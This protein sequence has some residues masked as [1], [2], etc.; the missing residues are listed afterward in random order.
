MYDL[1][2]RNGRIMDG[3][4]SSWCFADVAIVD[5]RIA[6]MERHLDGKARHEIDASG[7]VVS[8]G[9]IDTHSHSDVTLLVNP[10]AES[11]VRQGVTTQLVG[12][13]GFSAAPVRPENQTTLRRDSFI[14]S[15]EGYEW[16]WNDVAGY[17]AAL[18]DARPAINV[19]TLVG[20]GALRQYAL[21][22][23]ARPATSEEINV[24]KAE[25][26]KALEQGARGL[27]SGLTY[28]PGRFS[29]ADELVE[30]GKVLSRHGGI[31]HSHM[32][33][34]SRFILEAMHETV[35]VGEEAGVPVN[36]SHLNPPKEEKMVG[37]LTSLVEAARARGV[38]ATFD[39]IIWTR[40]GG[41]F[42]Q[43]LP[44]WAQEGGITAMKER[45]E[46]SVTRQEIARQLEEGA[47]DW[48]G[49]TQPDWED[50]LIARTGIPEHDAWC[51][52][53]IADLAA[54]RGLAP[55]ETALILL[56]EDDGQF[57]VAPTNKM[58]DDLN[59]I[60]RHPLSVP[61]S[62]GFALAPYGPLSRPTMPRSY[63]TFPRVLG[64]YAREWGVL[65]LEIAV[66]KMTS[67]PAQRMGLTERGLLRPGL[68]A[69]ITVFDPK[70]V[71]DRET[72]QNAHAFPS[73][74]EYVI[75]NGRLVVEWG[76]QH[77]V[78]PGHVL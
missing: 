71:I 58:Q 42:M 47:P 7:L 74:I 21:G 36:I 68:Y 73:G 17:R 2:L 3:T 78:R 43:M 26:D 28:A 34:Y 31:Y 59:Q 16:S 62:D 25:L 44:D 51:G 32:R 22:Q 60:L 49:W 20:H 72:Y 67:I 6:A 45:L 50:A 70:M 56:M 52:R 29:D 66:Q 63:G 37:E 65:P 27:S 76:R 57:W 75:V 69:D 23:A 18:T 12:H 54:E 39:N 40:G 1:V 38:E 46:D 24:M 9:F 14:F 53:T 41:P 13:C 11:A 61:V 4:G 35:R 33:D 10:R 30:L 5:A 19:A 8:P 55:A 15:F 48:Q 64:R 77:D